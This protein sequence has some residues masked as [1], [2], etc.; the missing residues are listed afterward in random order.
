VPSPDFYIR[1]GQVG[2]NIQGHLLFLPPICH[3]YPNL[4]KSSYGWCLCQLQPNLKKWKT[5]LEREFERVFNPIYFHPFPIGKHYSILS[6]LIVDISKVDT[7]MSKWYFQWHIDKNSLSL[8]LSHTH[9]TTSA[10]RALVL[11]TLDLQPFG[12]SWIS[13]LASRSLMGQCEPLLFK[14]GSTTSQPNVLFLSPLKN[15]FELVLVNLCKYCSTFSTSRLIILYSE[16]LKFQRLF[17]FKN[18]N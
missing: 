17:L 9:S 8:S 11:T 4:N 10:H 2:W 5:L 12:L 7:G 16:M 18:Q 14:F 6:R 13:H 1:F 15:S 3:L